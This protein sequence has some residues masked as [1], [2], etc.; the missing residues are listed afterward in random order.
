MSALLFASLSST[1]AENSKLLFETLSFV[2]ALTLLRERSYD[3]QVA[4]VKQGWFKPHEIR[5]EKN[6]DENLIHDLEDTDGAEALRNRS[7]G[8]AWSILFFSR[9]LIDKLNLKK[10]R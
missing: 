3:L 6:E 1:A 5:L 9:V 2:S 4:V 8:Q 10:N 7:R